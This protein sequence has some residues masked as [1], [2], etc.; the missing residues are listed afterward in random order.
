MERALEQKVILVTGASSGI[1]RA[2][3]LELSHSGA[4]VVLLARN[5]EGLA[6]TMN[7]MPPGAGMAVA[8]DLHDTMALPGVLEK[9]WQWHGHIDGLVHCAG[10]GGFARLRDTTLDF[11]T[12]RMHINCFIF[13]ELVRLLVKMKKKTAQLR[14]VAISS[15][16]S[17]GHEKYFTAYAASKAALEAAAKSLAVELVS[18]NTSINLLSPAVVDTPMLASVAGALD[19]Y[20]KRLEES[21]YQPLG[22]IPPEEV[23]RMAAYLLGPAAAHISG[24]VFPINAGAPC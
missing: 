9:A 10:V 5:E 8:A 2:T 17:K 16:A 14:V 15:L 19:D 6:E 13:V 12:E 20:F 3:C 21:G 1:G 24:A 18:R 11:M 23:A 22:V 4:S 7:N